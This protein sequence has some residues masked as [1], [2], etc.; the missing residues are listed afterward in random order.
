LA[1][2]PIVPILLASGD[3][4]GDMS[5]DVNENLDIYNN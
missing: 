3:T 2:N 1:P 4:N 5:L